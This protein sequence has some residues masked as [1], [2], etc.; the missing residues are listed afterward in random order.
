MVAFHVQAGGVDAAAIGVDEFEAQGVHAGGGGES[1]IHG[2]AGF[3]GDMAFAVGKFLV[4]GQR[5]PAAGEFG[6]V[7]ERVAVLE[8]DDVLAGRRG[9]LAGGRGHRAIDHLEVPVAIGFDLAIGGDGA[10]AARQAHARGAVDAPRAGA[11]N[12]PA[13]REP[14]GQVLFLPF[15]DE[16]AG[17]AVGGPDGGP[18]V[19]Q[20]LAPGVFDAADLGIDGGDFG[21]GGAGD[22]GL[23]SAGRGDSG[24]R[25]NRS[26]ALW[27]RPCW[28]IKARRVGS[29]P[30]M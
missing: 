12:G 15:P 2:G 5:L 4:A 3:G 1:G 30:F 23:A 11:G 8:R 20:N 10:A 17:D 22:H 28:D 18:V 25:R 14:V 13:L 16:G 9:N 24:S 6:E 19:G 21:A 7:G 29:L 26:A 27:S